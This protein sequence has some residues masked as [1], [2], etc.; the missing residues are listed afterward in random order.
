MGA[1]S[2]GVKRPEGEADNT[3]PSD[4]EVYNASLTS[5]SPYMLS[6]LRDRCTFTYVLRDS[7]VLLQ[8]CKKLYSTNST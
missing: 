1:L 6:W 5:M 7:E 8:L 2:A 4:T 3:S